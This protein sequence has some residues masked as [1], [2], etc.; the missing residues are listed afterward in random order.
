MQFIQVH[1]SSDLLLLT[2]VG[3][4][5]FTVYRQLQTAQCIVA[6]LKLIRKYNVHV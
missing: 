5:H 1:F 3:Y 6:I 4:R 2:Q